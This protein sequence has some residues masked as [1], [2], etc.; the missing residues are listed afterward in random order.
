[1]I[2]KDIVNLMIKKPYLLEMGKGKLS[3]MF[4]CTPDEIV[5]AKRDAREF[6]KKIP[7]IL[8]FDLETAPMSA[9]VWGRWNQNINLEATISEWFILCWSAKWLY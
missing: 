3:K 5:R 2:F 6:T 7:K 1:M 4:K 9:Y 8:I